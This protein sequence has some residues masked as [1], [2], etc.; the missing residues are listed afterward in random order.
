MRHYYR[1]HITVSP[2]EWGEITPVLRVFADEWTRPEY[3]KRKAVGRHVLV[4]ATAEGYL[5]CGETESEFARRITVAI[6]KRLD[7][8]VKVSVDALPV[9]DLPHDC[10][11]FGEI[12]YRKLLGAA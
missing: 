10:Y 6:W 12:D 5:C 2:V 1:M 7:R 11:E 4:E 3:V 9:E 8:Y